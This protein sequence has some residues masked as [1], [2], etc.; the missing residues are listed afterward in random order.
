MEPFGVSI[1]LASTADASRLKPFLE[2]G[3]AQ[4]H[5]PPDAPLLHIVL[6]SPEG[7]SELAEGLADFVVQY[8][9]K[10]LLVHIARRHFAGFQLHESAEI[11]RLS[12]KL[13]ASEAADNPAP[14]AGGRRRE[15]LVAALSEL[16]RELPAFHL[17]GVLRFRLQAYLEE[18]KEIMDYAM[19]EY[20][21]EK[22]YQDFISLLRYFVLVQEARIPAV[23]LIHCGDFDFKLFDDR[24][25]PMEAARTEGVL[26]ETVD[27]D[28][29]FEDL[30]VSTL[31]TISPQKVYIHTRDTDS[32]IIR[33]IRQI[34]ESRAEIC[35]FCPMCSRLLEEAA[36]HQA[37]APLT[38]LSPP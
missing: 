21:L 33:T 16:L 36:I 25:R 35:H 9:E 8:K 14:R 3:R 34:F 29:N 30:I 18:L 31:L 1:Q 37:Q 13:L 12:Q 28:L 32:Q 2:R 11:V 5:M 4:V 22:Q 23:H 26:L 27:E 17:E 15:K 19:E 20:L 10:D 24:L 38:P 6:E 7:L